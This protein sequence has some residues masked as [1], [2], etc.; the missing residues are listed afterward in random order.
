MKNKLYDLNNHFFAQLERLGKEGMTPKQIE[1]VANR[2]NAMVNI[3]ALIDQAF[4]Q[5]ERLGEEGMT[6]DQELG[7]APDQ[8]VQEFKRAHTEQKGG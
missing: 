7:M 8:I 5:L 1:Q 2:A 3:S 6:P 4:A